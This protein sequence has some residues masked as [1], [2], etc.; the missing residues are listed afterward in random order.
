LKLEFWL[1]SFGVIVGEL[2]LSI[3]GF[4]W[5]FESKPLENLKNKFKK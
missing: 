4:T 5:L 3:S 2:A 1:S